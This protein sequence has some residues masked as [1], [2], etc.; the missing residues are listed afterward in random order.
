[1]SILMARFAIP[2][3]TERAFGPARAGYVTSFTALAGTCS[4]SAVSLLL[5]AV[6]KRMTVALA[7]FYVILG[8][9]RFVFQLAYFFIKLKLV[10]WR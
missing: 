5:P 6:L 9:A 10:L 3:L 7:E 1:M 2:I 4:A 8:C